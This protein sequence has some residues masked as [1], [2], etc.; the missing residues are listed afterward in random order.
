MSLPGSISLKGRCS[1]LRLASRYRRWSNRGPR[2]CRARENAWLNG[3]NAG[4][5]QDLFQR[6]ESLSMHQLHHAE[7]QMKALLLA[8][9]YVVIGSQHDLQEPGQILFGKLGVH[10]RCTRL[11]FGVNLKQRRRRARNFS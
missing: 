11:L 4:L 10:A 3:F 6:Q 7:L 9:A 2:T 1:S 5:A 8:V